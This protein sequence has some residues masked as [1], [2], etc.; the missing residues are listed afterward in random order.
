[1]RRFE[2]VQT[3]AGEMEGTRS[4]AQFGDAVRGAGTDDDEVAVA[5]HFAQLIAGSVSRPH[6]VDCEDV[7]MQMEKRLVAMPQQR[8]EPE[9]E[10]ALRVTSLEL[11]RRPTAAGG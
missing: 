3:G 9:P 10:P 6:F 7:G 8:A 1:M 11:P 5:D 2:Q 4:V